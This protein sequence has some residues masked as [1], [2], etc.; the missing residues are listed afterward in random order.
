M[1]TIKWK[2]KRCISCLLL[3]LIYSGINI[4]GQDN[5]TIV[6]KNDVDSVEALTGIE[7]KVSSSFAK[8]YT[9][10]SLGRFSFSTSSLDTIVRVFIQD[11]NHQWFYNEYYIDQL[12]EVD[13]IYL[14]YKW[15]WAYKMLI[16]F[17]DKG[18]CELKGFSNEDPLELAYYWVD[19][20]G[21]PYLD[22]LNRLTL[23]VYAADSKIPKCLKEEV[24]KLRNRILKD[25]DILDQSQLV[26]KFH[27]SPYVSTVANLDF[28]KGTVIDAEFICNQN[29]DN[30]KHI[31]SQYFYVIE[32]KFDYLKKD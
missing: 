28:K 24:K 22:R 1:E 17:F 12:E 27:K 30:M 19:G 16:L 25:R 15:R 6:V 32:F 13:T 2:L 9:T 18:K 10:D 4:F 29:T 23:H 3:L 11:V 20:Y 5:Y 8:Y 21:I 26:V 14:H 7:V 31:A